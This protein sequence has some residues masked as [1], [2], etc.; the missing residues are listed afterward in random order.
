M[1]E[2]KKRTP[3]DDWEE[4]PLSK[5]SSDVYVERYFYD[6][7]K[8]PYQRNNLVKD[9]QYA[10]IRSTLREKLKQHILRQEGLAADIR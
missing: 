2:Y 1:E 3:R 6:L 9:P 7:K 10:E 8:D 5:Q 4:S